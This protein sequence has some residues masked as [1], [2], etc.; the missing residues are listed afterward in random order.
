M[1]TR[2]L[3]ASSAAIARHHRRPLQA[4]PSGAV[5]PGARLARSPRLVPPAAAP[6]ASCGPSHATSG[7]S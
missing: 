6:V 2:Q 7:G 5:P 3:H 1:E 4:R